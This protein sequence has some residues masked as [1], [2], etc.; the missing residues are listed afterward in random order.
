MVEQPFLD[1]HRHVAQGIL[2]GG[3]GQRADD[4]AG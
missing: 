4:D 1:R 2:A 3:E